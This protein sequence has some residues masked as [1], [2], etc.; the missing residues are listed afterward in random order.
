MH[1][2][3]KTII[4]TNRVKDTFAV[5]RT[6]MNVIRIFMLIRIGLIVQKRTGDIVIKTITRAS[7]RLMQ[8][9]PVRILE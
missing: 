3:I 9:T 5:I 7:W 2:V 8:N 6:F 1:R 4:K